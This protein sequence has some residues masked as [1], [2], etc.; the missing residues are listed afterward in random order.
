M[1]D[2]FSNPIA[3]PWHHALFGELQYIAS[4]PCANVDAGTSSGA[5]ANVIAATTRR[6]GT[7]ISVRR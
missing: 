4:A 2:D 7:D 5:N 3:M 6:A 1:P